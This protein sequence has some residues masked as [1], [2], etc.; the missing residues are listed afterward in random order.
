MEK[1]I[2]IAVGFTDCASGRGGA[3]NSEKKMQGMML[4]V[5]GMGQRV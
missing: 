2:E 5:V 3:A 4:C 1:F